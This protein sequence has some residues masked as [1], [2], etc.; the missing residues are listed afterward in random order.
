MR[1]ERGARDAQG[2][3]GLG[4]AADMD[5]GGTGKMI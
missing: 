4:H 1:L 2:G 5:D 3:R